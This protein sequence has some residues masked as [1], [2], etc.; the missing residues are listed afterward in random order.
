MD[1]Q[2]FRSLQEAYMEIYN[3][4]D[5]GAAQR[6]AARAQKLANQRKGQTP[7]RK[8]T[9]QSLAN[10][11]DER[12]NPKPEADWRTGISDSTRKMNVSTYAD[13]DKVKIKTTNPNKLR[14]QRAMRELKDSYDIYDII[15]SHLL[16]EGYAETVEAA[17]VM[18]V[19]MSEDWRDS[20]VEATA[21][22]KRGYD[23][24]PIRQRIAKSTGGGEAADKAKALADRPTYGDEKTAKARQRLARSQMRDFRNTTSSNP[25]LHGYAH[26]S[27]DP[28]VKAK[29][30]ARG[31][32]RGALTPREKKQLGR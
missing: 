2:D 26:Q 13:R 10:K 5:E 14:K 32:Q 16:D 17:E 31:A 29:Q 11:A 1:A 19:N 15:L 25:G 8:A 22:A 6:V 12:A 4:L 7:E 3:E 9:Y 24:A 18:M 21:M 30:A 27:D 23:E 28:E 20:I